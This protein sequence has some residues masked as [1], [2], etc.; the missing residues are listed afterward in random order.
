MTDDSIPEARIRQQAIY[1]YAVLILWPVYLFLLPEVFVYAGWW[2]ILYLIFPGLYL[3]T[4]LGYL[5]HESWHKYVPN[6]NSRFFYNVFALMILSDPQL[7]SMMHSTHHGQVNTFEDAEFHPTGEIKSRGLRIVYNWLEVVFGV[8]FLVVV[9]SFTIPRDSRFTKKYRLWKL[10][11]SALAWV[12]FFGGLGYLS[13]LVFGVAVSKVIL[14]FVLSFW[15]GSFFLHQSQLIEHGNL[16]VQG[17]FQQRNLRTRNLKPA[18]IIEK[19][20]LFLTHNDSREHVLHHTLTRIHSRP[21]PGAIPLPE[22]AVYI[23]M[24]DYFRLLGRM[25]I[26]EV[27]KENVDSLQ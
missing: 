8:A 9:A 2:V 23:T 15:L 13:H 27:N 22:T 20:F 4:W 18:G 17:T 21:F 11:L 26:G 19:V 5:M 14:S 6:V 1:F 16:F 7:Y 24:S 3:F 12:I 25:L 10:L